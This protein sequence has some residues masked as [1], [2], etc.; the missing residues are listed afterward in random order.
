MGASSAQ[1]LMSALIHAYYDSRNPE[2]VLS[3]VTED[4][5]WIGTEPYEIAHGKAQLREMLIRDMEAYPEPFHVQV[6][7]PVI[8]LLDSHVALI[9]VCGYQ[10][11]VPEKVCGLRVR[12]SLC[13][14]LGADG[15]LAASIHVSVPNDEMEK[16]NLER[17]LS[18]TRARE[19]A[20]LSAIPG[21]VAIYH[22][23]KDGRIATEYVSEGLAR[24]CGYRSAQELHERIC[25]N[26]MDEIVPEDR[27]P[28]LQIVR[29]AISKGKTVSLICHV[30]AAD[31]QKIALRMDANMIPQERME[32][33]D[34]AILYAV[35]TLVTQATLR[36]EAEQKRYRII[37][38]MLDLAYWEWSAETGSSSSKKYRDYAISEL[39]AATMKD[40]DAYLKCVHPDDVPRAR[41]YMDVSCPGET[42]KTAIMR[43]KM[44]D[45][46]YRWTE[47][48]ALMDVSAAG[49]P[50]RIITVM[51][52]VD[53]EWLKQKEQLEFD[54]LTGIYNRR[55][56]EKH[57]FE[58]VDGAHA[59]H[60]NLELA[61]IDVDSFKEINDTFGHLTGDL[62][63]QNIA[64]TLASGFSLHKGDF[65]A[66]FGGDEFLIACRSI[67]AQVFEQ[68]LEQVI[69]RVREIRIEQYPEL[70]LGISVGCAGTAEMPGCGEKQLMA[71]ADDRLY[72]AKGLG[73]NRVVA[74]D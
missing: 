57:L 71:K 24:S 26:A 2:A 5:E 60:Q 44:R 17:E 46:S 68:K 56:V 51:R 73:K 1:E 67:S 25:K 74:Q 6:E 55:Y 61:M 63:L 22:L 70:R 20:L 62:A 66:R 58:Y 13:C 45:G 47:M 19:R 37:L 33:D 35:H 28:T 30:Y 21:G 23:K 50:S 42:Q 48:F 15:W 10:L 32:G 18:R 40:P 38:G 69:E 3:C 4:V 65:V 52:D 9:D 31:H 53:K 43:A 16:C 7:Q 39:D 8:R 11:A 64:Q 29:G 12:A 14:V 49:L 36:T 27:E 59:A 34:Q 72:R 54:E 41:Q